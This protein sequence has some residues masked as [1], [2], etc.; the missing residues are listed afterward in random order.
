MYSNI[1]VRS[2]RC[3]ATP[4]HERHNNSKQNTFFDYGVEDRLELLP[5]VFRQAE[6]GTQI[7]KATKALQ[8]IRWDYPNRST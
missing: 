8:E 4:A 5:V 3:S 2:P 6:R 1:I 7:G